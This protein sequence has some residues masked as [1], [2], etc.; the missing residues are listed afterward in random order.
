MKLSDLTANKPLLMR[1]G[2]VFGFVLIIS[3][4]SMTFI[5]PDIFSQ[6]EKSVAK[7]ETITPTK[8]Q[9][10][11]TEILT[12][13]EVSEKVL[14]STPTSA[15]TNTPTPTP[16]AKTTPTATNTPVPQQATSAPTQTSAPTPADTQPPHT[17]VNYPSNGGE[18]T[19]KTDGKVC[20]IMGAPFDN[21]SPHNE[22]STA[23]RFDGDSWSSFEFEKAYSC[24]DSLPNGS[25][26][27]SVQSKDKAGNTES[28]QIISF[29]V[30]IENN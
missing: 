18:I 8:K 7:K 2:I 25:H 13:T 19:Y 24:K 21:Q 28:E 1:Y 6:G 29:T 4:V 27:L 17:V 11:P 26:T 12:P 5:A 15:V 22:I 9:P 23:Y 3:I 10:T 16:S 14:T 30:T 20:A